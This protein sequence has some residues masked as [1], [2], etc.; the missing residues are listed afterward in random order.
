MSHFLD[1]LAGI[2]VGAVVTRLWWNDAVALWKA[3][4]AKVQAKL[5][6]I[7]DPTKPPTV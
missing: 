2:I 7:F 4:R 6:S 1:F 3:D 5:S